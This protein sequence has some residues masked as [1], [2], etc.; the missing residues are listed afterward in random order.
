M[1]Y[2][3]WDL[4]TVYYS[5]IVWP[6][7][8]LCLWYS[9]AAVARFTGARISVIVSLISSWSRCSIA[10]SDNGERALWQG[11]MREI[12][13][14]SVGIWEIGNGDVKSAV[15]IFFTLGM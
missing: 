12:Y 5:S 8:L 7:W 4:K 3:S 15:R 13:I 9:N 1:P 6:V 2:C 11:V 10:V 14:N